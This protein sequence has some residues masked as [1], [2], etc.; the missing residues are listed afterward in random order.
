M[1]QFFT[2]LILLLS[3]P[4]QGRADTPY[5]EYTPGKASVFAGYSAVE[6]KLRTRLLQPGEKLKLALYLGQSEYLGFGI[7]LLDLLGTYPSNIGGGRFESKIQNAD[8]NALNVI[9]WRLL[10]GELSQDIARGCSSPSSKL[11]SKL[12]PDFS[13]ALLILCQWPEPPARDPQNL[14][15]YW[16][17]L[18]GFDLPYSEF[19]A[20][21]DFFLSPDLSAYPAQE[22]VAAMTLAALYNPYFLFQK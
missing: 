15:N 11:I 18:T 22:R 7:N 19:E 10:L 13:K 14:F 5:P 9:L 20:W 8:P 3:L 2:A 4:L 12:N 6:Q 17:A 16:I 21:S 1:I